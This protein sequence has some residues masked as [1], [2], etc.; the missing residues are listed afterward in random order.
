M[1]SI[2]TTWRRFEKWLRAEAPTVAARL[3]PPVNAKRGQKPLPEAVERLLAIHDGGTGVFGGADF[4]GREGIVKMSA[5]PDPH[6]RY[7]KGMVPFAFD[8]LTRINCG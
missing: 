2:E 8:G 4:L 1:A 7:A 5:M 6:R 3:R